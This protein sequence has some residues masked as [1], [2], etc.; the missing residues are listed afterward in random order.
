MQHIGWRRQAAA[1]A[2]PPGLKPTAPPALCA[3]I[4]NGPTHWLSRRVAE[5][6]ESL[7][8][9][10]NCRPR[11]ADYRRSRISSSTVCRLGSVL[12]TMAVEVCLWWGGSSRSAEC[13]VL[14]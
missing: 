5:V 9:W 10:R 12:E 7:R 6:T 1:E 11:M 2:A 13:W 14:S 4:T 3:S 8:Y